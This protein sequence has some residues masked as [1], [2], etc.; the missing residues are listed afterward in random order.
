M[1]NAVIRLMDDSIF[2]KDEFFR[3]NMT[4]EDRVIVHEPFT[5]VRIVDDESKELF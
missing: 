3:V 4:S 5:I 2:E 1:I